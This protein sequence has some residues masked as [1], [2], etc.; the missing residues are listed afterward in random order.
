MFVCVYVCMYIWMLSH[1]NFFSI[2]TIPT[3]DKYIA[4]EI[5]SSQEGKGRAGKAN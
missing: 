4:K 3:V 1:D 2:R 5:E